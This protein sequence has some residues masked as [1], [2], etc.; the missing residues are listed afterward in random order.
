MHCHFSENLGRLLRK[1]VHEIL[2]PDSKTSGEFLLN[3]ENG[4]KNGEENVA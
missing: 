4:K 2:S 3:K 1:P